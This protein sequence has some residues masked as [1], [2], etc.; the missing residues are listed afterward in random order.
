MSEKNIEQFNSYLSYSCFISVEKIDEKKLLKIDFGNKKNEVISNDIYL[1]EKLKNELFDALDTYIKTEYLN[2]N[3]KKNDFGLPYNEWKDVNGETF[4]IEDAGAIN[5]ALIWL[6]FK[7]NKLGLSPEEA[8]KLK[9]VIQKQWVLNDVI[10]LN[11]T[12]ATNH[13]ITNKL[14]I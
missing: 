8:Q 10:E 4:L 1:D 2:R 5:T 9:E 14:K 12:L 13:K 11:D 7:K 3:Y 6:E